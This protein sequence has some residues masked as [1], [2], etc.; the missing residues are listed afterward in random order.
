MEKNYILKNPVEFKWK[1]LHTARFAFDSPFYLDLLESS[2]FVAEKVVR[3]VPGRRLVAFGTWE[4]KPVVAK[5]FYDAQHAKRQLEK[6]LSGIKILTEHKIPTPV[7]YF[8][9]VSEDR[10]VYILLLERI[11]NAKNLDEIWS[12]KEVEELSPLLHAVTFELATQHVFGIFQQDLHLKNF[13]IANNKIY[14]LDGGQIALLTQPLAKK[15]SLENFALFLAQFGIGVKEFQEKLFRYYAALRGWQL[16]EA[17]FFELFSAIEKWNEKRWLHYEKKIFRHATQFVR[18]EDWHTFCMYDRHYAGAE[19]MQFLKNP[20]EIFNHK[21]TTVLKA[22]RSATVVK[23]SLDGHELVVKRYNIKNI[24]HRLRRCLRITRAATSWRL[25]HKLVLFGV[26]TAKPV[27]FLEKRFFSLRG[28]SYFVME[29]V[30]GEQADQNQ[31]DTVLVQKICALLKNLAQ[32]Q[33]T[34]G[35]LKLTNILLDAR[36]QPVFIDL[37]GSEEHV[38]STSLYRAWQKEIERLLANFHDQPEVAERF[39]EELRKTS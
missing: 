14:T 16:K 22:G 4:G 35:D 27:A 23:I 9:G 38:S 6:D 11:F 20:D 12:K 1:N 5:L 19:F 18:R 3:I 13:L 36:K 24:W 31:L 34:H 7:L 26:A 30:S 8:Q 21:T 15:W 33:M 25:A 37:D 29:Y 17:D 10:R 32:L 2:P 28:Q 39:R